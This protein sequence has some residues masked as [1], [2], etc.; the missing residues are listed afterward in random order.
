MQ[1]H[2]QGL[3][4]LGCGILVHIICISISV[5]NSESQL[6]EV[7]LCSERSIDPCECKVQAKEHMPWSEKSDVTAPR[8]FI[9]NVGW[10]LSEDK[11]ILNITWSQYRTEVLSHVTGY[12]LEVLVADGKDQTFK[13]LVTLPHTR[14]TYCKNFSYPETYVIY[15][16]YIDFG[17]SNDPVII[18]GVTAW[19]QLQALPLYQP[20][21]IVQAS[22]TVVSI[23]ECVCDSVNEL[24]HLCVEDCAIYDTTEFSPGESHFLLINTMTLILVSVLSGVIFFT[25]TIIFCNRNLRTKILDCCHENLCCLFSIHHM[26]FNSILVLGQLDGEQG[27]VDFVLELAYFFRTHTPSTC[28]VD[29]NLW[30]MSNDPINWLQ[31]SLRSV[32]HIIFV[33]PSQDSSEDDKEY[34]NKQHDTFLLAKKWLQGG[35]KLFNNNVI[36]NVSW[37]HMQ[38]KEKRRK[39][40]RENALPF[41]KDKVLSVK[42]YVFPDNLDHFV[43]RIVGN[44]VM[45]ISSKDFENLQ[46]LYTYFVQKENEKSAVSSSQEVSSKHCC[47][48]PGVSEALL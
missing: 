21:G 16:N 40:S 37:V 32:D 13:R 12:I 15:F 14:S 48:Q 38:D 43:R 10:G 45:N 34:P 47:K 28:T 18:P 9:E 27:Y 44:P 5:V 31:G 25:C 2:I 1:C 20:E 35:S 6:S 41:A 42:N 24:S 23:P 29:C 39:R 46:K 22:R 33:S 26:H 19:I 7:L 3:Y 30:N 4:L 36:M 11:I 8:P 17:Y